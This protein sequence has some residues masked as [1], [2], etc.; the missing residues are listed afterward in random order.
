MSAMADGSWLSID[1]DQRY[2]TSVSERVRESLAASLHRIELR[3]AAACKIA[4]R[5]RSEVTLLAVT[6]TVTS[7]IAVVLPSLGIADLGESRPQ[8]LWKKAAAIPSAR[9]HLIGHLQRNKIDQ[10]LP[11]VH[12]I[13]S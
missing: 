11:H 3:I 2:L 4:R 12:L 7:E 6:K 10:T 13:H 9:W 8:E 1:I 5:E